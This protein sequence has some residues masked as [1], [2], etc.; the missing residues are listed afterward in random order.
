MRNHGLWG[1]YA[2]GV[3]QCSSSYN[4]TQLEWLAGECVCT[5]LTE[6]GLRW[7]T[8]SLT[9]CTISREGNMIGGWPSGT[10]PGVDISTLR[11]TVSWVAELSTVVPM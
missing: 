2:D 6:L 4:N 1:M 8:E 10:P 11:Q 9:W 7:E 3:A 5:H